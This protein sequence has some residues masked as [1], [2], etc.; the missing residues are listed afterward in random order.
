MEGAGALSVVAAAWLPDVEVLTERL[1][2]AVF[3]DNPEWTDYRRVPP[4]DLRDGCRQYL[5][6]VLV[7][8]AEGRPG[9]AD[10]DPVAGPIGRHRAE[11]GVPLEVMLRTFRLGGRVVWEALL[12]RAAP[13]DVAALGAAA[14]AMWTV[15]DGLSSALSTAYRQAEAEQLR[16]DDQRRHALL[17]EVVAGGTTGQRVAD[18]LD[19]PLDGGYLI[20]V[21]DLDADGTAALPSPQTALA[22]LGVRSVWHART[23][24]LVGL[25]PADGHGPPFVLGALRSLARGRVAVAR[26]SHGLAGVATA[27]R[28][29][30]LA[31]G[32]TPKGSAG[33]VCVQDRYPEALL[34]RSPELTRRIVESW[35]GPVLR[36]APRE[37]DVLLETLTA[38]LEADRSAG[39]AA[40]RLYCHR[41][42]VLNRLHR[43][44]E[45]VG[46][47]L[48]GR[49]AYVELSL[50]LSALS[51]PD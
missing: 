34:L 45:L 36:L 31:L 27:H 24:T 15:V 20:V 46:R 12:E 32:T 42:T 38:W 49:Q 33:V 37:R 39:V 29:A 21:A 9:D 2:T 35:L 5:A 44:T 50:A 28:L 47:P 25:V 41:N 18:Q 6:R 17:E 40:E 10:D 30:V 14:T 13:V 23:D 3:T 8:V 4:E 22:A 19:L 43:V 7:L 51:L 11:Q 48:T 16:R 26:T 1:V